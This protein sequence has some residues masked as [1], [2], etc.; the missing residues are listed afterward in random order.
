MTDPNERDALS[1][2]T[3]LDRPPRSGPGSDIETWR[4]YAA[5]ET[6]RAIDGDLE[7]IKSRDE[8]IAL[9]DQAVE[10]PEVKEAPDSVEVH[11]ADEDGRPPVVEGPSGPQWMVPVKGGF[12]AEDELQR[13]EREREEERQAERHRDRLEQLKER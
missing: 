11:E 7:N 9:V 4:R 8:L 10:R 13:A 3:E 5:Q 2:P 6:G 1:T 12:V